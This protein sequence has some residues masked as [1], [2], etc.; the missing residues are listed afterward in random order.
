MRRTPFHAYLGIAVLVALSASCVRADLETTGAAATPTPYQSAPYP[1][2]LDEFVYGTGVAADSKNNKQVGWTNNQRL[3]HRFRASTTSELESIRFATRGGPVYSGGTGGTIRVSVQTDDGSPAHV[4]SGDILASFSFKPG[5]PSGDWNEFPRY[6][7]PSPA[8]LTEGRLYHIVFDNTDAS[9]TKNWIS[10]NELFYFSAAT[11]PRQPAYSDDYAVLTSGRDGWSV[12]ARD[13]AD[14]DLA[15]AD[16]THDGMGYVAVM[17]DIPAIVSGSDKMARE[18]F[19][20]SGGSRTIR[21]V[22]VR[23]RRTSGSDPLVIRLEESD[24]TLIDSVRIPAAEVPRASTGCRGGADWA[25]ASFDSSHVLQDGMT[26]HLR[27]STG[28]D[29]EY[30]LDAILEGTQPGFRS[31]RFTDGDGQRTT[32]GSS[33]SNIYRWQPVDLQFYLR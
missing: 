13:T 21:E 19:T 15:Y 2:S 26:Y 4:P 6:A 24:G 28:S 17:C 10:I 27:L 11:S 22:G 18:R 12:L 9:P 32:N 14:M 1:S 7:F 5:N 16:G 3:S 8:R 20:V 25:T 23:L 33:W 31:R 30:T 29:T